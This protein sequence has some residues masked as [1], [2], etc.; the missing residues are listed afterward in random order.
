[1]IDR[2]IF[3]FG[4]PRSGTTLVSKILRNTEMCCGL[5]Q[6]MRYADSHGNGLLARTIYKDLRWRMSGNSAKHKPYN[7]G[8]LWDKCLRESD[9]SLAR[10]FLWLS[11]FCAAG[12]KT[13]FVNKKISNVH[14]MQSI[15]QLFPNPVMVVVSRDPCDTIASILEQRR[16]S[17]GGYENRWGVMPNEMP[18]AYE[19]P[20]VDCCFQYRGLVGM[21]DRG[22]AFFQERIN[23]SYASLC[24]DPVRELSRFDHLISFGD[25]KIIPD[26]QFKTY[27]VSDEMRETVSRIAGAPGGSGQ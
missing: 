11:E 4:V 2:S 18:E 24:A 25:S 15:G 7:G 16:S 13:V 10:R 26:I 14:Y 8:A 12:K 9:K 1:M 3:I 22:E 6:S 27:E 19:D 21:I 5:P 17:M 20:I 23:I